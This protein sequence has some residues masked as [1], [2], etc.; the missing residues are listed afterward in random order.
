M[1]LFL[2]LVKLSYDVYMHFRKFKGGG[3]GGLLQM[4]L[5]KKNGSSN[6]PVI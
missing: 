3:G 1:L 5:H 2:K 4:N 6:R